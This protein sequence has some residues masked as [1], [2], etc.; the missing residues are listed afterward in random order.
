[1]MAS[2]LNSQEATGISLFRTDMLRHADGRQ[3]IARLLTA[4]DQF[5]GSSATR[6]ASS[7]VKR[8]DLR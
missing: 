8:R 1:M 7:L 6:V 2:A 4:N 5:A 3:H